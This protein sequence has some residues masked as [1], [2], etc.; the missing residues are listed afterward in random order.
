MKK[1]HFIYS[2]KKHSLPGIFSFILSVIVLISLVLTVIL[3][4]HL[5]GNVPASFGA[6]GFLCALFSGAGIILSVVARHQPEKVYLFANI[7]LALNVLDLLFISN[8]LYA[9]I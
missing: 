4:Y 1:R 3:S 8:I 2:D 6:V 5:K 9:G 7:G